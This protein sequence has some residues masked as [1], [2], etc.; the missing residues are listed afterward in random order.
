MYTTGDLRKVRRARRLGQRSVQWADR[1]VT[2]RS[3][4]ELLSIE[5]DIQLYLLQQ[6]VERD[7]EYLTSRL[8]AKATKR[9]ERALRSV[10]RI[11]ALM[12]H[13]GQARRARSASE[14]D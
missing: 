12:V 7:V 4:D 11:S 13:I 8:D 14:H 6:S 2:Y 1:Q 3:R 9:L 10:A 5:Q